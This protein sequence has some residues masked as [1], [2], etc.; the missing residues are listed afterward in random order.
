ASFAQICAQPPHGIVGWWNAEGDANDIVGGNN[1]SLENGATFGTGMVGQ[2]FQFDGINDFVKVPNAPSLNPLD[3]VSVEF[4]MK[5]DVTN[6]MNG[7]C[8][9]LV[10]TD[11]YAAEGFDPDRGIGFLVS[12]NGGISFPAA[13]TLFGN[14]N[15]TGFGLIPG[16]WHHV[17][18]SYDGSLV[19][20][21]VDGRL[22]AAIVQ[23]GNI[24]P[25]QPA[26]FLSF[27][28]ED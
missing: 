22:R 20:L 10:A 13:D 4:W 5:G 18:G 23:S 21:Y 19:K 9:G 27:G 3:E 7:C 17:A 6:P 1:G 14:G 16:R 28:S 11:F 24:S 25:M 12:T 2:A 26:S 15:R 8:Q